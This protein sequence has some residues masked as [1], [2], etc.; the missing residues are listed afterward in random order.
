MIINQSNTEN[1][2][3]ENSIP[4]VRNEIPKTE[5]FN[6]HHNMKYQNPSK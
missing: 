4:D 6:F 3:S 1:P 2:E 5:T